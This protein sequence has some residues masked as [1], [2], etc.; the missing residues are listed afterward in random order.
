[1]NIGAKMV[2]LGAALILS[3]IVVTALSLSTHVSARVKNRP[4][5]AEANFK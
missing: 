5:E 1:M 2:A 4:R 3:G